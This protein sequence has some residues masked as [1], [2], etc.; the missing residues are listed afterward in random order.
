MVITAQ[1]FIKMSS[2]EVEISGFEEG[3]K[4][5]VRLKPVSLQTMMIDG[6]IPNELIKVVDDLFK[7]KK[8]SNKVPTM[9]EAE[10]AS[11]SISM[12]DITE[13]MGL[14]NA[15]CNEAMVEPKFQ[16]VK[17]YMTDEQKNEIFAWTQ[18]GVKEIESFPKA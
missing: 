18:R 6:K 3:Q 8:E 14:M 15:V 9:E 11:K 1:E 7:G 4:I 13:M 16:E 2:K 17:D 5:I 12:K 10:E